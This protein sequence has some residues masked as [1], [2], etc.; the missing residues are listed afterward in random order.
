[1]LKVMMCGELSLKG[2]THRSRSRSP[3]TAQ[4]PTASPT[5]DEVLDLVTRALQVAPF[6]RQVV[7]PS[8]GVVFEQFAKQAW[9]LDPVHNHSAEQTWVHE[10]QHHQGNRLSKCRPPIYLQAH[11]D[12]FPILQKVHPSRADVKVTPQNTDDV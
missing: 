11:I 5:A 12:N 7:Q 8:R 9:K 6:Q 4:A 1:M 2:V 10:C 3:Y